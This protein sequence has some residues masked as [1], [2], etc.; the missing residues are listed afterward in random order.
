MDEL[1][2]AS[3]TQIA[4]AIREKK[5]SSEEFVKACLARIEAVNP[6]LN[7]VVQ[8]PAERALA[9]AR[10]A[11]EALARGE[12]RGPVHGVPFTLKDAIETAGVI[13]TGGTEGRRNHV[14]SADATVVTRLREAGAIL[15]GKTNCPELGWA[16]ESDNLIYGQHEQPLRPRALTGWFERRR[17]GDHCRGRLAVRPG[18]RRGRQRPLPGALHGHRSHQTHVRTRAAHRPLPRP[19]RH[20]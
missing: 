19:G 10:E 17:V 4:Q 1:L 20:A 9:A 2:H 14:P 7:A 6:R 8:L 13:S 16:W 11:D 5:I 3:A 12:V 18:Q 15:L